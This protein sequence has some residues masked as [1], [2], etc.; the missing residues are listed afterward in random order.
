MSESQLVSIIM[1]MYNSGR[2][3][4]NAIESVLAQTYRKWELFVV[5]DGSSD[6]SLRIAKQ[7]AESDPRITVLENPEHTGLPGSP[8][9]FGIQHAKGR[10]IA[11]LDS[12]DIWLPEKLAQQLPLFHDNRC[13]VVFSDYEKINEHGMRAARIIKAPHYTDYPRMLYGNVIGNLT[14]IFDAKKVGKNYFLAIHHEDYAFWLSVLKNGY[15]AISTDTITAL[16]R[17][18][19]DSVS[20][21]KWRNLSWQWHIYRKIENISFIRSLGYFLSYVIKASRKNMI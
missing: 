11:F 15:I 17:E 14:G 9:N 21:H 2:Y 3:V 6:D 20:A 12:D 5:D 4:K 19:D 8:R 18:R 1:P 10:Y 13:A 16:Y 7:Y